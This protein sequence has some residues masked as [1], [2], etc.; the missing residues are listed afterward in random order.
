MP[1]HDASTHLL[2][3]EGGRAGQY[4][5]AELAQ[6]QPM[7]PSLLSSTSI[8]A[9]EAWDISAS[10]AHLALHAP[11][12]LHGIVALVVPKFGLVGGGHNR[13]HRDGRKSAV[14]CC[15]ESGG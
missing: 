3:A 10:A 12:Q 8:I 5:D 7:P 1:E 6:A 9:R 2:R 15:A 14:Q 4:E 13:L 11:K